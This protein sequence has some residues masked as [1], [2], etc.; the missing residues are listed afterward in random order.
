M[1]TIASSPRLACL[2][3]LAC[4][5]LAPACTPPDKPDEER[6]PE[7]RS[8]AGPVPPP[9]PATLHGAEAYTK[10]AREARDTQANASD[11]QRGAIENAT[12]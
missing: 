8:Q 7:P 3:A 12:R 10:R 1:P 6:R 9:Q 11:R 5:G 2:V 4:A